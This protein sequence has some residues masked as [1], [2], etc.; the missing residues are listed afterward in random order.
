M[1][2]ERE[3]AINPIVQTSVQHNTQVRIQNPNPDSP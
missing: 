1:E 2:E 3:L